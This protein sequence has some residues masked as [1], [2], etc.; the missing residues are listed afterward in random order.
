MTLPLIFKDNLLFLKEC[1]QEYNYCELHHPVSLVPKCKTVFFK[2][3]IAANT[4][5]Q[6]QMHTP[7]N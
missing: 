7:P 5:H 1:I 2:F 4:Y 3:S 6:C